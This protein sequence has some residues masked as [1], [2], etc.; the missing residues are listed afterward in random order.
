MSLRYVITFFTSSSRRSL[1]P[2]KCSSIFRP[3]FSNRPFACSA[4]SDPRH[5]PGCIQYCDAGCAGQLC[6]R[7]LAAAR[8]PVPSRHPNGRKVPLSLFEICNRR[9]P[10]ESL[11]ANL[12]RS[13]ARPCCFLHRP[14]W[15]SANLFSPRR[16][17]APARHILG[18]RTYNRRIL[19]GAGSS[20][21]SNRQT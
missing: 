7:T 21:G 3:K 16:A 9:E 10:S 1:H 18:Y 12:P 5:I 4:L 17:A 11:I 14:H 19:P 15:A 13:F 2:P 8:P 6:E 20:P